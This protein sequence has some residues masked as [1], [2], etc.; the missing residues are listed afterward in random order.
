MMEL[1]KR[2]SRINKNQ[3]L[4]IE[5]F[6][7]FVAEVKKEIYSA[8]QSTTYAELKDV[9]VIDGKNGKE[10]CVRNTK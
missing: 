1:K 5:I 7:D 8:V 4:V 3:G 10:I 2:A 6:L 9:P